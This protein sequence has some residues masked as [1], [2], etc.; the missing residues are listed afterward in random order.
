MLSM[1]H[2]P[3]HVKMDSK[4]SVPP[5]FNITK[6]GETG[7]LKKIQIHGM[8]MVFS[9]FFFL[10]FPAGDHRIEYDLLKSF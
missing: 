4:L 6:E 10:L 3:K 1:G 7:V 5:P 8:K 2:G 9:D